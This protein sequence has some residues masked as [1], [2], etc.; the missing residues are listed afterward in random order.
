[1]GA[2][3]SLYSSSCEGRG[4]RRGE[5]ST[6]TIT[7]PPAER[8]IQI[9]MVSWHRPGEKMGRKRLGEFRILDPGT[10]RIA[11]HWNACRKEP[12]SSELLSSGAFLFHFS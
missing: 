4:L 3:N 6:N 10:A 8:E 1:M 7:L 12:T 5:G 11:P 2:E 9:F